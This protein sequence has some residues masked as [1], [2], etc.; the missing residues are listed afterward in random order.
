MKISD[1]WL[2]KKILCV[3]AC[4]FKCCNSPSFNV[5]FNDN[6]IDYLSDKYNHDIQPTEPQNGSCKYLG[7]KGC[8]FGDDKPHHCKTYPIVPNDNDTLVLSNWAWLNCPKPHDYEL[9]HFINGKYLYRLK[10]KHHNKKDMLIL[11]D[12]IE[13]ITPTFFERFNQEGHL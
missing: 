1:K 11:D 5:E 7:E 9:V 12:K 2:S 4:N 8:S 3:T 13:D 6:E 10:K